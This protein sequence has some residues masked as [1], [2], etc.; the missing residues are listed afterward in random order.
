MEYPVDT[1]HFEQVNIMLSPLLDLDPLDLVRDRLSEVHPMATIL[2]TIGGYVAQPEDELV[3]HVEALL[4]GRPVEPSYDF[5]DIRHVLSHPLF[6][7]FAGKLAEGE[8]DQ[9]QASRLRD[10]VIQAMIEARL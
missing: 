8:H 10:T 6:E 1:E 5:R 4:E 2:L 3:S 9:D 7:V